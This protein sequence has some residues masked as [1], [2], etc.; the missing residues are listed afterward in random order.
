[1]ERPGLIQVQQR[2]GS[3][4]GRV[5]LDGADLGTPIVRR[6]AKAGTHRLR[7][8]PGTPGPSAIDEQVELAAG[9]KLV[10]TFDLASGR[11][12]QV[13]GELPTP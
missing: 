10:L 11:L 6:P 7:I 5:L 1:M 9:K 3:P 12:V 2:V 13:V 8:E 4:I